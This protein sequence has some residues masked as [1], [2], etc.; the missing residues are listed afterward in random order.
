M[1]F[2]VERRIGCCKAWFTTMVKIF[3]LALVIGL[4]SVA[5][6]SSDKGGDGTGGAGNMAGT[7]GTSAGGTNGGGSGPIDTTTCAVCD[8]AAKC[9]FAAIGLGSC[10]AYSTA[11]CAKDSDPAD[12]A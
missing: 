9:C 8:A 1:W 6:G 12:Q 2:Q 11:A 5:C 4:L 10:N 7:G 3:P